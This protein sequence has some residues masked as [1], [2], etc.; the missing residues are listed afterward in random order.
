MFVDVE[1]LGRILFIS[2]SKG[3]EVW[4][5]M[6]VHVLATSKN[7]I[8]DRTVTLLNE[9]Y[10]PVGVRCRASTGAAPEYQPDLWVSHKDLKIVPFD[11]LPLF[12]NY[13]FQSEHFK[14]L[15]TEK[16]DTW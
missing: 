16:G 6:C 5:Y 8:L 10:C 3:P 1:S 7:Y 4:K 12:L 11:E 9:S 15:F 2:N 14:K 13:Q